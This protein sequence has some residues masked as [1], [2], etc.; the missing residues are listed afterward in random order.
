MV[1]DSIIRRLTQNLPARQ[2]RS[3]DGAKHRFDPQ[4]LYASRGD[5]DM[6]CV[7]QMMQLPFFRQPPPKSA[8]REQ[9]GRSFV[10][11]MRQLMSGR[12]LSKYDMLATG[13]MLT[14]R[15]I[16]HAYQTHFSPPRRV[17]VILC[18]G[19]AHNKTLVRM[20]QGELPE[21]E[22]KTVEDFAIPLQAKECVSFAMLA[23]ACIDGVP[24]NLPQV[25]GA[26]RPAVL[27]KIVRV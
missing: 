6:N 25:T 15:S 26:S 14:A 20:L 10:S 18:G 3:G 7:K 2:G 1:I 17:E 5:P 21:T 22:F 11:G 9:F 12:G 8:G 19:G 16:A 27:G 4:G 13:T 23:A 24:A